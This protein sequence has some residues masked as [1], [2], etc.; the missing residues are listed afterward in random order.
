MSVSLKNA[1]QI[2]SMAIVSMKVKQHANTLKETMVDIHTKKERRRKNT[3]HTMC[4]NVMCATCG[5]RKEL[6]SERADTWKVAKVHNI[7][8][9][10]I[11]PEAPAAQPEPEPDEFSDDL[12]F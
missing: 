8:T 12:P 3:I 4:I 9:G 11:E 10:A 5:K 6:R 1:V 7:I 2:A